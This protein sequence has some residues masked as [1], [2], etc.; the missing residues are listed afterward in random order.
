MIHTLKTPQFLH[1]LVNQRLFRYAI[2][3]GWTITLMVAL[4]QSSSQPVVGPAAPPGDPDPLREVMLTAGHIIG[5]AGLTFVWW[6]AFVFTLPSRRALIIS[7]LIAL[8][9]GTVTE[10]LQ[11][12]IADRNA[13]F[14]DFAVNWLTTF[15]VAGLIHRL[16]NTP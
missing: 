2:A 6:W 10:F 12:A 15:I 8:T 4:L 16:Q 11:T 14:Y 3:L 1:P 5:F 13:S 7:V 9:L